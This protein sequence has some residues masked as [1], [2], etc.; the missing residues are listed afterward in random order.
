MKITQKNKQQRSQG[1]TLVEIVVAIGLVALLLSGVL[2]LM[3]VSALKIDKSISKK[4]AKR[5]AAAVVQEIGIYDRE[6]D[7]SLLGYDGMGEAQDPPVPDVPSPGTKLAMAYAWSD[8]C[9]E[10]AI[11]IYSY[12]GDPGE[13]PKVDGSMA[14]YDLSQ[15]G[16]EGVNYYRRTEVRRL[17]EFEEGDIKTDFENGAIIG[18]VYLAKFKNY[19]R[20][21]GNLKLKE[22]YGDCETEDFANGVISMQLEIFKLP[23]NG[24]ENFE[25]LKN[26]IE[27]NIKRMNDEL[28]S[29][30]PVFKTNVSFGL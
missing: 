8:E 27:K 2:G 18:N 6:Q 20:D 13:G 5:A 16:I 11:I 3:G 12:A 23:L 29:I 14:A 10:K 9:E 1:F 17:D 22:N 15:G 24:N 4:E 28:K 7:G 26:Y 30:R 21:G 19:E 25:G